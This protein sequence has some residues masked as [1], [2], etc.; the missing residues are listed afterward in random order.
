MAFIPQVYQIWAFLAMGRRK[1]QSSR[2][3]ETWRKQL[4]EV[5]YENYQ[6]VC[7]EMKEFSQGE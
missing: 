3:G 7:N 5:I 1:P 4:I 6:Y 2:C